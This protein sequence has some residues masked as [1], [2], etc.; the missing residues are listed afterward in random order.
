MFQTSSIHSFKIGLELFSGSMFVRKSSQLRK[1]DFGSLCVCFISERLVSTLQIELAKLNLIR[2]FVWFR[3]IWVYVYIQ[4]INVG[5]KLSHLYSFHLGTFRGKLPTSVSINNFVKWRNVLI[6]I[7]VF[8]LVWTFQSFY[9]HCFS[10]VEPSLLILPFT[11][12][13]VSC[14]LTLDLFRLY[15]IFAEW[16]VCMR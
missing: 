10:T 8:F 5:T 13:L 7:R 4:Q 12:Y 16:I 3:N 9:K 15:L 11:G 14:A 2:C 1:H 6:L